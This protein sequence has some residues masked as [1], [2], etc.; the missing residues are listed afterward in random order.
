MANGK[1]LSNKGLGELGTATGEQVP[2]QNNLKS[3]FAGSRL[4]VKQYKCT[5][6]INNMPG[7][8]LDRAYV[9]AHL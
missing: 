9:V 7:G 4:K 6:H 8:A 1:G 3:T 5:I 2:M